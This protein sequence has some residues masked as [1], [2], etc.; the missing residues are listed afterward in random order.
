MPGVKARQ[1]IPAII[2]VA[3]CALLLLSARQRTMPLARKLTDLPAEAFGYVGK[4]LVISPEERAMPAS[5]Y[6]LRVYQNPAGAQFS[7]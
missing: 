1:W 3:G 7:F 5:S 4:D 6:L 2:L